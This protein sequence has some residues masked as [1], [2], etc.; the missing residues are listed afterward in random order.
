MIGE[1]KRAMY[2]IL[3]RIRYMFGIN[4]DLSDLEKESKQQ[5]SDIRNTVNK[6]SMEHPELKPQITA[7]MKR[8]RE[9]YKVPK[10][11]EPIIIPDV[12]LKEFD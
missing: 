10:F 3:R 9:G 7:Y 11:E 5:I 6:L 8:I 12:F 1:D 2:D 4:L